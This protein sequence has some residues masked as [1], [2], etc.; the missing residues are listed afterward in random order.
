M[1]RLDRMREIVAGTAY[2]RAGVASS[3]PLGSVRH[4]ME[5]SQAALD[6]LGGTLDPGPDGPCVVIR[7]AYEADDAYGRMQLGDYP[8]QSNDALGVL[9]GCGGDGNGDVGRGDSRQVV[10]V[11]LETTGLSGGAGTVGFIIGLGW[12]D[13]SQFLTC[14]YLLSSPAH[15]RHMLD[16]V[17]AVLRT[18]HT[19]ITF[20][21]RSFDAPVM[22]TRYAFHGLTSPLHT[23]RHVDLLHPGR[24]LW[25]G[26]E[27]RLV[28]L[29]RNVLGLRRV[30]DVP[31][32]EIPR[33]Y[34]GFLRSGD[35]RLLQP[36]LEH[37]RLDLASLGILAGLACHLVREGAS[38]TVGSAQ[39]LGLGRVYERAGRGTWAVAAYRKAA[40][41][42]RSDAG[43]DPWWARRSTSGSATRAQA[44]RRL[45]H[46]YR[47][48]QRHADAADA[49]TRLLRL[50]EIPERLRH[51]ASVALAV[52]HEHR[53]RD[54]WT[55]QQFAVRA[56]APDLPETRRHAV[57][58]R[59]SRLRRKIDAT[60]VGQEQ[61]VL[62]QPKPRRCG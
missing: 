10:C 16:A 22:E 48:Q 46:I 19:I 61:Q 25:T 39:A 42:D 32:A 54:P 40:G 6:A 57:Q 35:A 37:N 21:G 31:G 53:L 14:Q 17:A 9:A 43:E 38:A 34:V 59:L 47:R 8:E 29:E 27:T 11:D 49:W 3:A 12:F 58:H 45:A 44:L 13:R 4:G 2:P 30:G 36:V 60:S 1:T 28:S 55:A 51:E 33:R 62:L 7:R 15:E 18:A 52:H 24:Q 20:N 41:L 50:S 5:Y 23:L 56:L 26:D